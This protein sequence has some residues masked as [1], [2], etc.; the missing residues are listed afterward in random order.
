MFDDYLRKRAKSLGANVVN[1]LY[2]RLEQQGGDGPITV[3]YNSYEEGEPG[4]RAL[5]C[6]WR[7]DGAGGGGGEGRWGVESGGAEKGRAEG[8]GWCAAAALA[9]YYTVRPV[10]ACLPCA[11]QAQAAR[12]ASPPSWRSTW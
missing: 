6:P 2:M 5:C 4:G 8:G 7:A 1:G 9:L 10:P 3:H 11:A 12:W